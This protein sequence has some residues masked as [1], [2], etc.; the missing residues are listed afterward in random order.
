MHTEHFTLPVLLITGGL[1]FFGF[2][3]GKSMKYLK[4]P[5]IVG[6]MIIGMIAGPSFLNILTDGLQENLS[7]I[8]EL[9]LG[10]VAFSIGLELSFKSLK[11]QG[12]GIVSVIFAESFGAFIVVGG[13][14]YLFTKNMPLALI[15]G[16]LAPASDP[17]GTIAVIKEYR[18]KGELT[19]A[20]YAVTGF[21]DGLAIIIFGFAAS[22]A[23][24]LLTQESGGEEFSL[25]WTLVEP[26]KEIIFSLG[27]GLGISL[28]VSLLLRKLKNSADVLILI[29]ACVMIANGI[30]AML[31]LSLILTN[32]VIGITIINTQK[33]EIVSKLESQLSNIMPLFFVLFFA[34]AGAHLHI[35][36][37]PAMGVLGI[38]YII[39]R[40]TGLIGGAYLGGFVGSL[41]DG[42][43]KNVGLGILCQAGVAI[44]LALII[45]Q[46]FAGIGPMVK[47][48]ANHLVHAGDMI[49]NKTITIVAATSIFFLIVGPICAK[50]ALVRGGE[51]DKG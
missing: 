48:S 33:H 50:I 46:D 44:G 49:G 19:K 23:K 14:I 30:S 2:Y 51:I 3:L 24:M 39:G 18:T 15:M 32:M 40:A 42:V 20:L 8:T 25:F 7:F 45:K 11:S 43:R 41:P 34:I 37:L 13:A 35:N 5:S 12:I 4:L 21:D 36:A 31:H 17:A 1:T 26:F 28:I 16:S 9:A 6:C 10:F 27:L 22:I 47:D 29:F 38:I